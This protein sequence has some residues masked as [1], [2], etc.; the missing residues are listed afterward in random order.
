MRLLASLVDAAAVVLLSLA[1]SSVVGRVSGLAGVAFAPGDA[2]WLMIAAVLAY[3][4]LDVVAGGT[5]GRRVVG[6]VIVRRG[7]SR[8]TLIWLWVRFILRNAH[9][10]LLIA[11]AVAERTVGPGAIEQGGAGDAMSVASSGVL[12]WYT[13]SLISMFKSP[14]DAALWDRIAGTVVAYRRSVAASD[15][16]GRGFDP[17]VRDR[18]TRG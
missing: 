16:E 5:L 7:G 10:W 1:I 13:W 3:Q 18:D 4:L 9:L 8:P 15:S 2:E 14:L 6:A 17:V 12:L 11:V